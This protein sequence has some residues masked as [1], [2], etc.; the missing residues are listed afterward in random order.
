MGKTERRD[1]EPPALSRL[2]NDLLRLSDTRRALHLEI[3]H[4]LMDTAAKEVMGRAEAFQQ[5]KTHEPL[6]HE[7]P[8]RFKKHEADD[9]RRLKE[10]AAALAALPPIC[11]FLRITKGSF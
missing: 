4:N 1:V 7:A 10:Q 8:P 5:D 9:D 11:P 6:L 3:N 2:P